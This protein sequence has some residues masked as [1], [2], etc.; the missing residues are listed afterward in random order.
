MFASDLLQS[1]LGENILSEVLGSF[2]G[3]CFLTGEYMEIKES[4]ETFF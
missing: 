2:V 1:K 4:I 3:E